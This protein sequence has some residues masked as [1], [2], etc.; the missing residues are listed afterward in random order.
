MGEFSLIS[1]LARPTNASSPFWSSCFFV[2]G[3]G[4][5]KLSSG[6]LVEEWG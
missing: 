5:S 1:E 2:V 4:L 6:V 3:E